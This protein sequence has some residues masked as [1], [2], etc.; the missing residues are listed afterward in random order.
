MLTS[1]TKEQLI[2]LV[3]TEFADVTREGGVSWSEGYV[4]DDYGS[5]EERAA[6]RAKDK[7]QS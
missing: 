7:D 5:K 4:I 1:L 2:E 3:K 6:A